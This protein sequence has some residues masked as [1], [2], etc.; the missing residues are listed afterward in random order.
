[1]D[2]KDVKISCST[3]NP[4]QGNNLPQ[5]TTWYVGYY[6]YYYERDYK[7]AESAPAV[8]DDM[9]LSEVGQIA[10]GAA[11]KD[12]NTAANYT[13][14]VQ[15]IA[16]VQFDIDL[17]YNIP[18]DGKGHIVSLKSQTLPSDYNYLIVPKLEQS[19]FLIARITN[20]EE[21]NLLPGNANI[22][23]DNTYVGKTYLDPLALNDTLSL[24]LGRD[25]S[26]EVKRKM[27]SEKS[28]D[29]ILSTN[30]KKTM[31]FEI[32]VRNGKSITTEIIVMDQIPIS[33]NNDIKVEV[34][35]LGKGEL[36]EL[37]G[38]VTWRKK[39]KSKELVTYNLEFEITYPKGQTLS[40]N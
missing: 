28:T 15:T 29:K 19:A 27:L 12:L 23:F 22:Y 26:I 9:T 21:V 16:N 34:T 10:S 30:N 2:W 18:S 4:T 6:N 14:Q 36:D 7:K 3:G 24:S 25:K 11:V 31:A 37:S 39:I 38:F 17:K 5:L 20:W 33:Q 13:T 35:D 32:S 8:E 40:M 1:M